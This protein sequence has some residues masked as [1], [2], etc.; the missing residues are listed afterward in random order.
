MQRLHVNTY[1]LLSMTGN[2]GP[3]LSCLWRGW[4]EQ[5]VDTI[6]RKN[7]LESPWAGSKGLGPDHLVTFTALSDL[8]FQ[9]E[10]KYNEAEEIDRRTLEGRDKMLGMEQP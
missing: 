4:L 1:L 6:G 5:Q 2:P 7:T 8:G 9:L 10:G 3:H